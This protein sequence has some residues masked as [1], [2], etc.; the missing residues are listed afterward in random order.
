VAKFQTDARLETQL[1]G[2]DD[3]LDKLAKLKSDIQK[4]ATK[5]AARSGAGI[6]RKAVAAG[7]RPLD[8]ETTPESIPKNVAV[9]FAPHTSRKVGGAAFRVGIRGGAKSPKKQGLTK[10]IKGR[11]KRSVEG[12]TGAPGGDTFYWRFLEFGTSKIQGKGFMQK[13]MVQSID[14]ATKKFIAV[15]WAEIEKSVE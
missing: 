7:V 5:K 2:V 12:L 10:K 9:Q 11:G 3:V 1:Q 8:D 15:I 14:P 6:I 4:N 13:A